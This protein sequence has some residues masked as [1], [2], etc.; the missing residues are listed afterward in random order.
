LPEETKK[1]YERKV[2]GILTE[3]EYEQL[4]LKMKEKGMRRIKLFEVH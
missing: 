4:R 1:E 3:Q 2:Q